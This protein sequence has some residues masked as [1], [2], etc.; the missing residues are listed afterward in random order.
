LRNKT[1]VLTYTIWQLYYASKHI[2][3]HP[4]KFKLKHSIQKMAAYVITSLSCVSA[5]RK[6]SCNNVCKKKQ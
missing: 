3:M 5:V 6:Y 1:V 2:V 4:F